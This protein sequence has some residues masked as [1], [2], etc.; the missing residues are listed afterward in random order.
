MGLGPV[1]YAVVAHYDG[2]FIM[3]EHDERIFMNSM[4]FIEGSRIA[5]ARNIAPGKHPKMTRREGF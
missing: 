4:A 5:L 2:E 3:R 1:E